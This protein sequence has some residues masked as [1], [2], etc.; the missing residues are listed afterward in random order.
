MTE[1]QKYGRARL[2]TDD[3]IIRRVRCVYRITKVTNTHA[4]YIILIALPRQQWL[5]E[6][7][8]KL[9]NMYS[10]CHVV[11]WLRLW[12]IVVNL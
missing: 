12:K 6:C 10:A 3:D 5:L 4:E 9:R 2:V 8:S 1:V 11:I 7:A